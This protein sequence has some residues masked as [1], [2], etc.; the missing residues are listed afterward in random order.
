MKAV[1]FDLDGTLIDSLEDLAGAVNTVLAG[2][3]YAEHPVD[4]YKYFIGD[5]ME[6]LLR[7]AVPSDIDDSAYLGLVDVLREEYARSWAGK[8]RLYPGIASMLS[9]LEEKGIKLAILSNKPHEFALV[10]V[11]HFFPDTPFAVVQGS[12]RGSKAKP[13]PALALSMARSLGLEPA[14]V[15]FMG[16]S[17]TDMKTAVAAGMLP[18][19][20]LWGFRTAEELTA[21]GARALL[22]R[23]EQVF[24]FV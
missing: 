8:T 10:T 20:V 11:E 22:E 17:G 9:G 4:A 19:G 21:H 2:A 18:V 14:E 12:P 6:T 1:F 23:P 15:L 5:G 16:D 13:D 24:D 7:R 3:G